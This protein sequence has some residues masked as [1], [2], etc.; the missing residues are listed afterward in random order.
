MRK[1]AD[2][3]LYIMNAPE[4]KIDADQFM[5]M[6]AFQEDDWTVR[7]R[8]RQTEDKDPPPEKYSLEWYALEGE[9]NRLARER[10]ANLPDKG[11]NAGTVAAALLFGTVGLGL[12]VQSGIGA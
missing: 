8:R 6:E 1:I 11:A 3:V 4:L 7:N 10:A 2:N 9:K 12:L 5:T